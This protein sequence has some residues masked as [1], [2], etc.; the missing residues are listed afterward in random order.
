MDGDGSSGSHPYATGLRW[1]LDLSKPAGSRLS[2]LEVKD[3]ATGN[4]TN[5]DMNATYV[6]VTNDFIAEG[7]DGYTTFGEIFKDANKVEDTKLLYTQSF[8]D[9]VEK[10]GTISRPDRDD[11]SHKTVITADG[12]MLNP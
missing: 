12:K 1:D 9:Y 3:R 4:W 5:L 8:I 7:R 2:N 10:V 6:V 11:Y